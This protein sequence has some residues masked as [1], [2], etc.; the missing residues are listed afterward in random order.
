MAKLV[1]PQRVPILYL[2]IGVLA[3]VSVVP[4]YFYARQVVGINRDRLKTNEMLLQN[5]I[6]R[7]LSDGIAQRMTN[8]DSMLGNLSSAI[9]VTSGGD[10]G[11]SK[12]N[13]P[14]LRALLERFV[15]SSNDVAYATI[16][17]SEAKGQAVGRI[18]PDEFLQNELTRGFSAAREGRAYTGQALSVGSGANR[19]TIILVTVPVTAGGRV[20]GM[21]GTAV[22][23]SFLQRNLDQ[24]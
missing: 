2:I 10:I 7:A 21:L 8:L 9:Q 1:L 22:D 14:E 18:A 20:I 4:M 6:T 16:L 19:K 17:N 3:L 23:L 13:A 12:I 24:I 15:S 11:S 5:T